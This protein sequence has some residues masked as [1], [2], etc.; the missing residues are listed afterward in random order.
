MLKNKKKIVKTRFT[1]NLGSYFIKGD[2]SVDVT[3]EALRTIAARSVAV[4]IDSLIVPEV[5][6][7]NNEV[8]VFEVISDCVPLKEYF[9]E[10]K[11]SKVVEEIAINLAK[12]H[13]KIN[14]THPRDVT[15][16]KHIPY[17][18]GD[19]NIRNI[20]ICG[21]KR[22]F[23]LVDWS[24][25]DWIQADYLP[26][27]PYYDVCSF[28]LSLFWTSI[29]RRKPIKS[30]E[31]HASAF[32]KAYEIETKSELS[33]DLVAKTTDE[34]AAMLWAYHK[35]RI[36]PLIATLCYPSIWHLGEKLKRAI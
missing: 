23:A 1:K 22:G 12:F 30:P 35:K 34:L 18:H 15:Q 6:Y 24:Y 27:Q 10:G 2:H 13:S 28:I 3:Q 25:P 5:F 29:A 21:N 32:I 19:F 33:P 16:E 8:I 7:F 9:A 17:D 26:V 31:V 36:G 20:L 4:T 11:G 14:S